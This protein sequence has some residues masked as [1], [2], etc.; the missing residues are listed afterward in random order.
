MRKFGIATLELNRMDDENKIKGVPQ[1][2]G[3]PCI[4]DRYYRYSSAEFLGLSEW[5]CPYCF[6]NLSTDGEE[7]VCLKGCHRF[8]LA[9]RPG[10]NIG[11]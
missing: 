2:N 9:P 8:K 1:I 3:V 5:L 10:E 4:W 6:N 11:L 7:L